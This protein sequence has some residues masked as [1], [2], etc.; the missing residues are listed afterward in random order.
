[1]TKGSNF[2]NSFLKKPQRSENQKKQKFL[3]KTPQKFLAEGLKNERPP[4]K[5]ATP[6]PANLIILKKKKKEGSWILENNQISL[7]VE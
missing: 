4:V 1:M 3:F 5:M 7:Y 2:L 6:C